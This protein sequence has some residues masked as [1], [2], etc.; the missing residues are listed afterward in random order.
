VSAALEAIEVTMT[1]GRGGAAVHAL[2]N[3]NLRIPRGGVFGIIGPNGA[4]KSTLF[5]LWLGLIRATRGELKVLGAPVGPAGLP[6]NRLIAGS[7]GLPSFYPYLT[8]EQTLQMLSS[9]NPDASRGDVRALLE[10]VG[11]AKAATQRVAEY[12]A[13]MS[14]RLAIA[15]AMISRSRV[16]LLDEP[17]SSLDPWGIRDIREIVRE[18]EDQGDTTVVLSSH[19]LD[20]V[21]RICDNVAILATGT[22]TRTASLKEISGSAVLRL[23][24]APMDRA[25]TILGPLARRESDYLVLTGLPRSEAPDVIRRLASADVDVFE[26]RWVGTD[27]EAYLF[28]GTSR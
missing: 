17:M 6:S 1:H 16:L 3:L 24:V 12:S 26:A 10:R 28:E 8:G 7:V 9:F 11:L 23:A 22:V 15:T 27:L 18:L 2:R 13:G 4:G 21:A 5:R 14:Q 20:E 25:L 19:Q